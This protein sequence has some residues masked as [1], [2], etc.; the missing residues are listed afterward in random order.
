MGPSPHILTISWVAARAIYLVKYKVFR[1]TIWEIG[2][3][4][5]VVSGHGVCPVEAVLCDVDPGGLREVHDNITYFPRITGTTKDSPSMEYIK[6]RQCKLGELCWV[7][8]V[9]RPN[10]RASLARVA[11]RINALCG[12]DVYRIGELV[13][14]AKEWQPATALMH[15][16]SSRPWKSPGREDRHQGALPKRG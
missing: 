4:R 15:A 2:S 11:S 5:R 14:V 13:R 9:S 3:P 10:I 8:T 1:A 12:S 6:L 16:S 7:A